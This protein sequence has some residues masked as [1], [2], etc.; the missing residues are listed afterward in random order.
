MPLYRLY[1]IG[2]DG[3]VASAPEVVECLDDKAAVEEAKLRA[4]GFPVEIWELTRKVA[5]VEPQ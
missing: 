2:K 5:L 4:D 3:H 1:P